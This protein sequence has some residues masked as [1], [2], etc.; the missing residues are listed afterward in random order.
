M[1]KLSILFLFLLVLASCSDDDDNTGGGDAK[2]DAKEI[3]A[4]TFRAADNDALDEDVSGTIDKEEKTIAATVPSGTDITALRSVRASLLACSLIYVDSLNSVFDVNLS[5]KEITAFSLR[6]ADNDALDDDVSA[7]IDKKEKTIAATVP[8]GTDVTALKP[9][10]AISEKA[11]VNPG[12]KAEMDFSEEVE[13]T[14]TA[15]DGSTQKYTVIVKVDKSSAKE[16]RSYY[17]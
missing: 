14:V 17:F 10:L 4:F 1:K 5:A 8:S 16:I 3:T 12:D 15:E 6:A 13:Y 2:S 11:T 7:T 9:T